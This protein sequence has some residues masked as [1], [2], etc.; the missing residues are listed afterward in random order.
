NVQSVDVGMDRDHLVVVDVDINARGYSDDRLGT[1]V[2]TMRDR[3]AA[4][5]GVAA[6]TYSENGI[7]S[8]SEST[9]NLEIPGFV[10]REQADSSMAYDQVGAG[11]AHAIGGRILQG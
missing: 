1:L 11:Y 3:V 5:P 9:T 4:I 2:H 8:G 10:A 6:V 7:F